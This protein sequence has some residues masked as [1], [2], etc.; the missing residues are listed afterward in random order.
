MHLRNVELFCDVVTRRS[1]SEAAKANNVSQS[2]A[3]QAV[4][5]LEKR[6]GLSLIDRSKRPFELTPAG[7]V[8]FDGCRDLLD[9]FRT[10]EDSIL[11]MA[12][13]VTG[14]VRV[15]AIYSVGL[16]QMDIYVR[17]FREQFPDAELS[18][19][20]LHPD[21]VY[22]RIQNDD[23]D[24]GLVSFPKDGGEF[25]SIDWKNQKMVAIVA[26]D[27]RLA[28]HRSIST[29]QLNG[30]DFV[31]FRRELTIGRQ[32]NRWLRNA[33]IVVRIVHE[34]DTVENIKRAVE[35]GSGI[36]ILPA[37]TVRREVESGSLVAIPVDG[38]DWYR[39]LGVIH[40]R[41]KRLSTA[42]RKF[43]DLLLDDVEVF[44]K[45]I[46]DIG[47]QTPGRATTPSNG[48]GNTD[49]NTITQQTKK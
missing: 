25:A 27:H 13:K 35:I 10:I 37:P 36:A 15:A 43:V 26:T 7:E 21:E 42:A 1:F 34:F 6:L 4:H 5:M 29:E 45:P 24:L 3:S 39:P 48:H 47:G 23:A 28:D 12:D 18:L 9:S 20:Y 46:A 11:S 44:D 32:V 14:R 19:E 31:G 2:A 17:R 16:L 38:V 8:Y 49:R 40:R 33:G 41:H 30:E 22:S